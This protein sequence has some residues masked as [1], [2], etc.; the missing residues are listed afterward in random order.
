VQEAQRHFKGASVASEASI[1]ARK[2]AILPSIP[3][4]V[5]FNTLFDDMLTKKR[6]EKD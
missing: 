6:I 3:N 1:M 2:Q 5:T 4:R